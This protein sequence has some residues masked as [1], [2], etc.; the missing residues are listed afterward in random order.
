MYCIGSF[1]IF[2]MLTKKTSGNSG[3][4][5][6]GG[7]FI[8]MIICPWMHLNGGGETAFLFCL[9]KQILFVYE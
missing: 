1:Q 2:I 4:R 7:W 9:L 6:K 5:Q 3:I 8:I